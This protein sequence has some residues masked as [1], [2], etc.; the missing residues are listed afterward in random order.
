MKAALDVYYESDRAVAACVVFHNWY[1]KVPMKLFRTF[2]PAIRQYH[3]GRFYERELPCLLSVLQEVNQE[4]AT[5]II[6]GFV[7][8]KTEVGIGLGL[9]L[10]Q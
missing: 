10:F 5:I 7:H 4:F 6:D 8:L 1:D 9:H 2:M 3:A